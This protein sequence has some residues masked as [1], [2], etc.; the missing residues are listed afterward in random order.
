MSSENE[1]ST[2]FATHRRLV[3]APRSS[4]RRSRQREYK[5]KSLSGDLTTLR[6]FELRPIPENPSKGF[7]RQRCL[8]LGNSEK[9]RP[10]FRSTGQRLWRVK[11]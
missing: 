4:S 5:S 6:P 10:Q 7:M 8:H 11:P 1:V 3:V 9:R 2:T